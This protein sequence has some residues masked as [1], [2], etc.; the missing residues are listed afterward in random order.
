MLPEFLTPTFINIIILLMRHFHEER[1][2]ISWLQMPH[3]S[4]NGLTPL[5]MIQH[6]REKQVLRFIKDSLDI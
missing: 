6:N 1:L 2:V 4:F 3:I 5:E